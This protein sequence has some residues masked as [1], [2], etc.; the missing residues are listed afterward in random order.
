MGS[1]KVN[2]F[3][4]ECF[5]VDRQPKWSFIPIIFVAINTLDQYSTKYTC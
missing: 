1:F 4:K 5:E 3:V 2:N